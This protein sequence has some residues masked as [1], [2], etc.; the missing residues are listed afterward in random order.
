MTDFSAVLFQTPY[1]SFHVLMTP[2]LNGN[3]SVL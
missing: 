1:S 3:E 2:A